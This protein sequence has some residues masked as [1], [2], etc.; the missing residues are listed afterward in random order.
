MNIELKLEGIL[1]AHASKPAIN[2]YFLHG[3]KHSAFSCISPNSSIHFFI[4]SSLI[5]IVS[6]LSFL[7]VLFFY[8]YY[9][10]SSFF[11]S[12]SILLDVQWICDMFLLVNFILDGLLLGSRILSVNTLSFSCKILI[13]TQQRIETST[14]QD[15]GQ[16]W[17]IATRLYE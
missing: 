1:Y 6:T 16:H 12:P 4:S 9:Q 13:S 11:Y 15:K 10:I 3:E 8:N 2:P 7:L 5:I 17:K 14:P